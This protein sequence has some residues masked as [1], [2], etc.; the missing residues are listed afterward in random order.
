MEVSRSINVQG[1][2]FDEVVCMFL[3][4]IKKLYKGKSLFMSVGIKI[5]SQDPSKEKSEEK[6]KTSPGS[7][8]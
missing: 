4:Y 5:D 8:F 1:F 3:T 6:S 7:R 2:D